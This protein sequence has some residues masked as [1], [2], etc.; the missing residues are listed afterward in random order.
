MNGGHKYELSMVYFFK[1][2]E[3]ILF[4]VNLKAGILGNENNFP[5]K[6]CFRTEEKRNDFG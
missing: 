1:I 4:M 2:I 6:A 5:R 3:K